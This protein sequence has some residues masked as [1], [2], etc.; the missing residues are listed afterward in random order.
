MQ[1]WTGGKSVHNY[2]FL[3][4]PCSTA[5]FTAGQK[6]L[7]KH[8]ESCLTG[9]KVDT[10]LS[11]PCQVLRLAGGVHPKTGEQS[12]VMST[13][14]ELFELQQLMALVRPAETQAA[15]EVAD[16]DLPHA[17]KGRHYERMTAL[18]KRQVVQEA[19][20]FCPE[21]EAAGSGTYEVARDVLAAMVQGSRK[22]Q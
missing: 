14:G 2:W 8:V 20:R 9:V 17:K 19:L 1:L 12:K 4:E 11:K 22:N 18:E 21:R 3:R 7:F 10:S 6:L 16:E 15:A 13:T 5:A